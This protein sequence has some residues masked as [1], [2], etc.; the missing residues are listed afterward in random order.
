MCATKQK[1]SKNSRK[2]KQKWVENLDK[3]GYLVYPAVQFCTSPSTALVRLSIK[4]STCLRL[5]CVN[6]TRVRVSTPLEA[7]NRPS[8][9]NGN[10][11]EMKP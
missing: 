3:C 2:H 4:P 8:K 11:A 6:N 9:R 1:V 7:R 5:G 10:K